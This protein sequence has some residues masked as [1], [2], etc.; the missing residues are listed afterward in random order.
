LPYGEKRVRRLVNGESTKRSELDDRQLV[1][2]MQK[3][4]VELLTDEAE[5]WV[6]VDGSDL[7][8]PQAQ[9]MEALMKV[10]PL[11]GKG[12]VPGYRTINALGV[13]RGK[14]G[15]L[16]HHLFSSQSDDFESESREVQHTLTSVG[17]ALADSGAEITYV[18]DR[19]FDDVAVW[20]TI[21]GQQHHLVCRLNHLERLV[22]Q[23][24]ANGQP[25]T[26][27]LA[28]A[29][30]QLVE[31]GTVEAELRVRKRGQRRPKRQAVTASLAACQV[32]VNASKGGRRA[33][34]AMLVGHKPVWLVRVTLED[35]N[36]EPWWLL[37][38]WSVDNQLEASRIFQMYCQRWAVEDGFKFIKHCVGWEEVQMLSLA[39]IRLLVA[40]G[41]VAAGFLYELGVT[42]EWVEIQ[43][44]ARLG[45]WEKRSNR[46]PGKIIISRG[47]RRLLDM[48][49]V[50]AVLNDHIATHGRLPPRIASLLGRD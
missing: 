3:R 13:A 1:K 16:Y 26:L 30:Q 41:W 19:G 25:Q 6:I 45:G 43:L 50:E 14:R 20:G 46:V 4:A 38:D 31:R 36:Y 28:E 48:M 34:G 35:T 40:L 10:R 39:D 8:K 44:L 22:N 47:L 12:L 9:E 42:W 21:W 7:R 5:I 11:K 33:V 32:E 29:G 18:L 17:R 37:T 24:D 23:K 15:L 2:R 27:S 49:A